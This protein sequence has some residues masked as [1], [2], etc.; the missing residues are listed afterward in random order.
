ML[1]HLYTSSFRNVLLLP[2]VSAFLQVKNLI[3]GIKLGMAPGEVPLSIASKKLQLTVYSVLAAELTGQELTTPATP[4]MLQYESIQPKISIGPGGSSCFPEGSYAQLSMVQWGSNPYPFSKSVGS[5]LL[6]LLPG[7]HS[8]SVVSPSSNTVKTSQAGTV[9]YTVVLQYNSYTDLNITKALSQSSE[10]ATRKNVTLPLCRQHNGVEYVPC[11]GCNISS[12][13]NYNVTYSCYD[14]TQICPRR[15]TRRMQEIITYDRD[16]EGKEEEEVEEEEDEKEY[17]NISDHMGKISKNGFT[18]GSAMNSRSRLHTK[19]YVKNSRSL[20]GEDSSAPIPMSSYGVVFR[21]VLSELSDV[22]TSNPFKLDTSSSIIVLAFT[23]TFVGFSLLLLACFLRTDSVEK[24][25]KRYVQRESEAVARKLFEETVK[26]GGNEDIAVSYQ[27]YIDKLNEE[28]SKRSVLKTVLRNPTTV[29][30]FLGSRSRNKDVLNE[31]NLDAN[32]F[33]YRSQ[34]ESDSLEK[35]RGEEYSG[36]GGGSS[37]VGSRGGGLASDGL[38]SHERTVVVAEF[39]HKLFPGQ[40]IF[41]KKR[42]ALDII[43][44]NHDYSRM[45]VPSLIRTRT[46]RYMRSL[47]YL[48]VCLFVDT[49]FYGLYFPA[50]S[51]C[52]SYESEVRCWNCYAPL[53]SL[54]LPVHLSVHLSECLPVCLSICLSASLS[55]CPSV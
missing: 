51:D 11:K 16:E 48:L 32:N 22:L 34:D 35:Y 30:S 27:L 46:V 39:L 3:A 8:D 24:L 49:V 9:A 4:S 19:T 21:A 55:V 33:D 54:L 52:L 42:N 12:Y 29:M 31:A 18:A 50:N 20:A 37:E 47:I 43:L 13:T 17:D 10:A 2:V 14:I 28:N 7:T 53:T 36:T 38:R 1:S 23:G 6:S 25:H 45:F 40:S 5:P 41:T 15:K 44:A 26:K